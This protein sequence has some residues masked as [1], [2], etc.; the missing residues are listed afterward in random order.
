MKPQTSFGVFFTLVLINNLASPLAPSLSAY[1][2]DPQMTT[3]NSETQTP[4]A[5]ETEPTK[6]PVRTRSK[7]AEAQESSA[8]SVSNAGALKLA[9]GQILG[10]RPIEASHLQVVSTYSTVGGSRPVVASGLIVKSTINISGNR[11][12]LASTLQVSDTYVVMGNRPVAS[13]AI[14]DVALL[15][16]YLD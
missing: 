8:L 13:N 14:D 12:V 9:K 11:P 5:P 6:P 2:G 15:M 16:G 1:G 10:N 3:E 7:K 4:A